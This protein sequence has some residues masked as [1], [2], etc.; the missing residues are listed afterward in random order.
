M[1]IFGQKC[2]K[3]LVVFEIMTLKFLKLENFAKKINRLN[4]GRRIHCLG[5]YALELKKKISIRNQ[6]PQV[7]LIEK[8]CEQ[9]KMIILREKNCFFGYF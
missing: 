6:H 5:F 3:D 4:L 2:W 1:G 7:S 9:T 8:F